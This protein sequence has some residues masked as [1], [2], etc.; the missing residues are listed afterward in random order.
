MIDVIGCLMSSGCS[1]PAAIELSFGGVMFFFG[2]VAGAALG[3]SIALM[4]D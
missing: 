2:L 4:G 3:V 1:M